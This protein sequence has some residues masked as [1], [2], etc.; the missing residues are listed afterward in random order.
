MAESVTVVQLAISL[1]L[2]AP[3]EWEG[4]RIVAVTGGS[5]STSSIASKARIDFRVIVPP[6]LNLSAHDRRLATRELDSDRYQERMRKWENTVTFLSEAVQFKT[7]LLNMLEVAGLPIPPGMSLMCRSL[8]ARMYSQG[9]KSSPPEFE[10]LLTSEADPMQPATASIPI[11]LLAVILVVLSIGMCVVCRTRCFRQCLNRL[12]GR[13]QPLNSVASSEQ[14]GDPKDAPFT[15]VTPKGKKQQFGNGGPATGSRQPSEGRSGA[16]DGQRRLHDSCGTTP[17]SRQP[18]SSVGTGTGSRRR[19]EDLRS[20]A[21]NCTSVATNIGS[22]EADDIDVCSFTSSPCGTP[23]RRLASPEVTTPFRRSGEEDRPLE[24]LKSSFRPEDVSPAPLSVMRKSPLEAGRDA[25][26]G[27]SSIFA[28]QPPQP[29][30][31]Q[32]R[33]KADISPEC[34]ALEERQPEMDRSWRFGEALGEWISLSPLRRVLTRK[35]TD[36]WDATP[37]KFASPSLSRSQGKLMLGLTPEQDKNDVQELAMPN[38][39]MSPA[40]QRKG[41]PRALTGDI[42]EEA[43]AKSATP[44]RSNRST[45]H[46]DTCLQVSTPQA[47]AECWSPSESQTSPYLWREPRRERNRPSPSAL[48]FAARSPDNSPC[49]ISLDC[50]LPNRIC[51]RTG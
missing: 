33:P 19:M 42:F 49:A 31:H 46:P 22:Y 10:L 9:E 26:A 41:R 44:S 13:A 6:V 37:K 47:R 16:S 50:D 21:D 14:K 28:V 35:P 38:I 15:P 43:A 5:V 4:Q 17:G 45:P 40:R 36:S 24:Q 30:C 3:Q 7:D 34:K 23:R 25:Q 48:S 2:D 11:M 29:P 27:L 39:V 32:T 20:E 1:Q 8:G 51:T 18:I 12:S